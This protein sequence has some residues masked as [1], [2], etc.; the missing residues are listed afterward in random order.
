VVIGVVGWVEHDAEQLA[1]LA[2][3]P[4]QERLD[5]RSGDSGPRLHD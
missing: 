5:L 2:E 3:P 4:A 1:Q